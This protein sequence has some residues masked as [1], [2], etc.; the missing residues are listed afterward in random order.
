MNI[1]INLVRAFQI[2]RESHE[3]QTRKYTGED[4]INHPIRVAQMVNARGGSPEQVK[5]A[6]LHDTLED[7][8]L[9]PIRIRGWF[10]D[11]VLDYVVELT[12]VFTPEAFPYM[13]RA[14]RKAMECLRLSRISPN[15]KLIK[16]CDLIDNTND[17][18]TNDP[19][20]AITYLREKADVLEALGYGR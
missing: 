12:D 10:G 13:T 14:E 2:A 19:K 11:E 20:F 6:L 1:T 4:Y 7:T 9:K 18:V 8:N 17:I 15:A 3:G 5:A 16:L